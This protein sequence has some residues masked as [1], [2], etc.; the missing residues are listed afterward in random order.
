MTFSACPK[1]LYVTLN[2][3]RGLGKGVAMGVDLTSSLMVTD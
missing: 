1:I 3:G 2:L